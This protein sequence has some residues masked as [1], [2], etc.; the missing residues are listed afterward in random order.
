[1]PPPPLS[2]FQT[3]PLYVVSKIIDHVLKPR[4]P[5][6]NSDHD[7]LMIL[8]S[9]RRW[10]QALKESN[11]IELTMLFVPGQGLKPNIA[12]AKLVQFSTPSPLPIV[13]SAKKVSLYL[14]LHPDIFNGRLL[15]AL[16][17][18]DY[19]NRVLLS[20]TKLEIFFEG[21]F[22]DELAAEYFGSRKLVESTQ[23]NFEDL[24]RRLRMTLPN[25]KSVFIDWS[26]Y[27][28]VERENEGN[29]AYA[30]VMS[31]MVAGLVD[32]KK[33]VTC[34]D[35]D[36]QMRDVVFDQKAFSELTSFHYAFQGI[37]ERG[38]QVI[39][40]NSDTL[41]IITAEE[42]PAVI[43]SRML[44]Q[45]NGDPVVYRCLKRLDMYFPTGQM[46]PDTQDTCCHFPV[47]RKLNVYGADP[48]L[49]NAL[50]NGSEKLEY[51]GLWNTYDGVDSIKARELLKL[52]RLHSLDHLELA[53]K[54]KAS[55]VTLTDEANRIGQ[56][57]EF[58]EDL[59]K[60]SNQ[61][62]VF[63]LTSSRY[64]PIFVHMLSTQTA[65]TRIQKLDFTMIAMRFNDI[66][67]VIGNCQQLCVFRCSAINDYPEIGGEKDGDLVRHIETNMYPLNRY[68]TSIFI[69]FERF[70]LSQETYLAM[71]LLAVGCP[72]LSCVGCDSYHR[73]SLLNGMLGLADLGIF[74]E[75]R[76][77]LQTIVAKY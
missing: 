5:T 74:S 39:L 37:D 15:D 14:E 17:Q 22:D 58:L 1:M 3:L 56:Y 67:S 2:P 76:N 54:C 40:Q 68:L 30:S 49:T 72:R 73:T 36:N 51:L 62:R 61:L 26:C 10:R 18:S 70:W 65:F 7:V 28:S 43:I 9:C 45:D 50:F 33:N 60:Q 57:T 41:Q 52:C 29:V 48:M 47:L 31:R 13:D 32:G 71:A 19:V 64:E 11:C 25:I 35:S 42:M 69:E 24:V 4:L 23:Q 44:C 21:T 59:I 55:Q 6:K 8:H 38:L 53:Y 27:N 20:A 66:V 34:L 12:V 16:T 46:S 75:Y 63:S 77:R